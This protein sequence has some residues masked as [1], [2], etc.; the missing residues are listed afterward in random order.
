[1]KKILLPF[2]ALILV[3]GILAGC[4]SSS[5]SGSSSG[6]SKG[7]STDTLAAAKEKGVLVVGSSNDAPFAYI[8]QKTHKFSGIDAEII[9]EI[10]K[11]LGIPKVEMKQ[12]KFENL[13]L[14]LNNKNIDLV[15]DAMYINPKRQKIAKFTNIWYKEGEAIIVPTNSPIKSLSDLKTRTVGAQKGTGFYELAD[16]LYKDGNIKKLSVFGSQADL[17]M[18]ANTGK[19]D[20]VITDGAV[21]AYSLKTDPSLKLKLLSPYTPQAAG[22]IGAAARKSDTKLVNAINQQLDILKENGF[23]EKV[24]KKYGMPEDYFVP[25]EDEK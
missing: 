1:M 9:T 10:A 5:S 16:K 7:N 2:L 11:R 3:T 19:V 23:I 24:L 14:E 20:A 6:S 12:T 4:N 13:L 25:V 8:D 15:T 22:K 17:L 18:A 21:A